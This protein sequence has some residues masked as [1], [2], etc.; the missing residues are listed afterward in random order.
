M[1]CMS[2]P[3]AHHLFGVYFILSSVVKIRQGNAFG[4]GHAWP[5]CQCGSKGKL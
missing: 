5:Y 4:N 3:S 1:A 2:D